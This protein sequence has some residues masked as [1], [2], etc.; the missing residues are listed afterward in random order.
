[1]VNGKRNS[2]Y[3]KSTTR[4]KSSFSV[5]PN[6]NYIIADTSFSFGNVRQMNVRCY[7]VTRSVSVVMAFKEE[8]EEEEKNT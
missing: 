2:N 3:T 5:K 4:K 1:M 6:K 8:E 7:P